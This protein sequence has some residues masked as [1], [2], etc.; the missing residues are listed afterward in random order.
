M[1]THKHQC[2]C[3]KKITKAKQKE[4]DGEFKKWQSSCKHAWKEVPKTKLINGKRLPNCFAGSEY[5]KKCGIFNPK[6]T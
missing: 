4:I 2:A 6:N 1:P 3:G 5:C